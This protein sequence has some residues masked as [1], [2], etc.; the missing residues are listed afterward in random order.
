MARQGM[1]KLIRIPHPDADIWEAYD[2]RTD[3]GELHDDA[4]V[5]AELQR[6]LADWHRRMREHQQLRSERKGRRR[7]DSQTLEELRSFGYL[8]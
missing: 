7:M 4:A 2:L 3:P 1:H 5:A 6:P 8:H